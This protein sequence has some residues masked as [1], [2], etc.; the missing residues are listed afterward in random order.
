MQARNILKVATNRTLELH[1]TS[2]DTVPL[3]FAKQTKKAINQAAWKRSTQTLAGQWL[4]HHCGYFG[5]SHSYVQLSGRRSCTCFHNKDMELQLL[6]RRLQGGACNKPSNSCPYR[7]LQPAQLPC[8]LLVG[9][10]C[11]A[12]LAS[13]PDAFKRRHRALPTHDYPSVQIGQ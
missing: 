12:Y 3:S 8:W 7:A 1:S 10:C 11:Y 9:V 4:I 5:I 2:T 13:F 6:K